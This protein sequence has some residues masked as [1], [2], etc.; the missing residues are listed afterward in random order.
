MIEVEHKCDGEYCKEDAEECYCSGCLETKL[1]AAH[2]E[3]FK[4]GKSEGY[5][6]G[7]ETAQD[8]LSEE[9]KPKTS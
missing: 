7:Y 6:E 3:G 5:N 8:E 1:Q 9:D 4:E 2:D